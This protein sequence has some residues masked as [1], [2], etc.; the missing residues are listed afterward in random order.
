MK[1]KN[2]T[3]FEAIF[4]VLDLLVKEGITDCAMDNSISEVIFNSN[5]LRLLS[6]EKTIEKIIIDSIKNSGHN[7]AYLSNPEV[8]YRAFNFYKPGNLLP[9]FN[10][11]LYLIIHEYLEDSNTYVLNPYFFGF[12]ISVLIYITAVFSDDYDGSI[13]KSFVKLLT[14]KYGHEYEVIYNYVSNLADDLIDEGKKRNDQNDETLIA[15][16]MK[17]SGIDSFD[18]FC[19]LVYWPAMINGPATAK[20]IKDGK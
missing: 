3:D 10:E 7:I 13:A 19:D 8:I 16:L 6:D 5:K 15:G 17:I 14:K 18:I 1:L 2:N 9:Q 20:M 4:E 12:K 11:K